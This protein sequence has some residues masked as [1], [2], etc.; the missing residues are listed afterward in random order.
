M[1]FQDINWSMAIAGLGLFL[2]GIS[3]MGDGLK[4]LAG[5]KLR[6]YIDKYTSSPVKGVLVGAIMTAIIQSSGATTV[7]TISFVRAG[8]MTLEQAAGIII[9]ANIGTTITAFLIGLNF[10]AISVYFILIG[11]MLLLFSSRRKLQDL[12]RVL[13]GIGLLFFGIKLMGD[14]LVNLKYVPEFRHFAELCALNPIIGL[15]GGVVLTFCM[16]SSSAAIGLIQVIYESGAITFDAVIPFLFGSNVGTCLT[17]VIAS[18]GGNASSKRAATLHLTFNVLGSILGM[19]ALKPLCSF[20]YYLTSTFAI[21]PM[22][23]IA[24]VHIIFNFTTAI[25][26]LPFVDRL[27]ALVRK[28]I[29]GEEPKQRK[30][31]I[32]DLNVESYPI[33]AA[34]LNV[35]YQTILQ[36]GDIVLTNVKESEAYFLSKKEDSDLFDGIKSNEAVINKV[37]HTVTFFL[38][39]MPMDKMSNESLK[40]NSLYL[41]VANN[42]ERIG[43]LCMNMAEFAQL[44][45]ES[46]GLFSNEALNEITEMYAVFYE[47]YDD[48]FAY[49]EDHNLHHYSKLMVKEST[50]YSMEYRFRQ[51]HFK[52]LADKTTATPIASSIYVDV[53]GTIER[54][55]DHCCNISRSTF[56]AFS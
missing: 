28:M 3:L 21:S 8:L 24:F 54:M 51:N 34:A 31:N 56:E 50:M 33:P 16:Q 29:K 18:L 43:D 47:M 41:E 35:A 46:K 2:F 5:D 9:G 25:L 13:V 32:E 11:S 6:D 26:I 23:Q 14:N 10:S 48:V 44:I 42:L 17:A 49:L 7:I 45:Y 52:R 27:C 22:M 4:S 39:N 38:T 15:L 55:G 40:T 12:S 53:L 20:I 30:L 1:S 37:V 36:L 19:I